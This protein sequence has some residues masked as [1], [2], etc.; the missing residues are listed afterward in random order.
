LQAEIVA[1]NLSISTDAITFAPQ[2]EA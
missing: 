1:C 2:S